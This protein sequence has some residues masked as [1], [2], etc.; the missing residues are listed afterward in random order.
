MYYDNFLFIHNIFLFISFPYKM[1][2]G[3]ARCTYNMLIGK[4][5]SVIPVIS[6]LLRNGSC[7]LLL[8]FYKLLPGFAICY[9][10]FIAKQNQS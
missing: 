8:G 10:D 7:N 4:K 1:H 3:K 2:P 5:K 9:L 6:R